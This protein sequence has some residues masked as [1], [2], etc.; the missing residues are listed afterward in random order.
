M[1]RHVVIVDREPARRDALRTAL[2]LAPGEVKALDDPAL[3]RAQAT[4]DSAGLVLLDLPDDEALGVLSRLRARSGHPPVPVIAL[5]PSD[6]PD[7]RLAALRAGAEEAAVRETAPRILQA[8]LRSLLR[9]REA[10]Q[11]SPAEVAMPVS[12]GLADGTTPFAAA[13]SFRNTDLQRIRLGLLAPCPG[14]GPSPLDGL[15]QFLGAEG[16]RLGDDLTVPGELR[17]GPDLV[18]IDGL[19]TA[20]D[21]AGG[22]P[23]LAML[24]D[25]RSRPAT[26][27][28]ATLILLPAEAVQTTALAL[29]LGAGDV[30]AGPIGTEEIAL[31]VRAILGRKAQAERQRDQIRSQLRAAVTDPLT[32]LHNLHHADPA[33]RRMAESA[34]RDGGHL[35]VMMLDID[36][37][38]SFNDRY[39][40]ATG[41]RVLI[42]VGRRLRAGLRTAD[43]VARIGGEEF[44]AALPGATL[45][46]ACATAERLRRAVADRPF[47]IDLGHAAPAICVAPQSFAAMEGDP[48]EERRLRVRVTLSIGVAAA[49]AKDLAAGLTPD[50]LL[51]RADQALYAAKAAGRDA[52]ATASTWPHVSPPAVLGRA[53]RPTS[54]SP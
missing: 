51:A 21:L 32:G 26:R 2:G 6:R 40:H 52:V 3:P 44:L 41:N 23:L 24:S 9:H 22:A 43:L 54:E 14:P 46:E 16:I 36:H 29:D 25:L 7:L 10:T 30:A 31:R 11:D 34:R 38:K 4:L 48:F 35:A 8:R 47:L 17:R 18:V 20:G 53:G 45:E 15:P 37:F 42:E 19:G 13:P 39:G 33:L 49:S 5:V 1:S 28:A 12:P 50:D 27:D